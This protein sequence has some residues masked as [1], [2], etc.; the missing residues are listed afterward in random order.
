MK[1]RIDFNNKNEGRLLSYKNSY[2]NYKLVEIYINLI[3]L[4]KQKIKQL[5]N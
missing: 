5:W 3:P 4:V 1:I 2:P